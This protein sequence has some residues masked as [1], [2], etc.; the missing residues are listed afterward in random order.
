MIKLFRE[1]NNRIYVVNTETSIVIEIYIS[2]NNDYNFLFVK[3]DSNDVIDFDINKDDEMYDIVLNFYNNLLNIHNN[4]NISKLV[5]DTYFRLGKLPSLFDQDGNIEICD[6]DADVEHY[7][8]PNILRLLIKD[9]ENITLQF[10]KRNTY[11]NTIRIRTERSAYQ[12]FL[13]SF[14]TLFSDLKLNGQTIENSK[15]PYQITKK[16]K[17]LNEKKA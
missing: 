11:S 5:Y 1:N 6:D 10:Q 12:E 16:Y 4:S 8:K 3:Y 2:G 9:N 15:K 17:E 7:G 13:S 14:S